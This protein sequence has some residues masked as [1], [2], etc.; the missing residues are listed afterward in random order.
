MTEHEYHPTSI[1]I[2]TY[3]DMG[4]IYNYQHFACL[5]LSAV[6]RTRGRQAKTDFSIGRR[7]SVLCLPGEARGTQTGE[8]N[9][10]RDRQ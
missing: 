2:V 4:C 7:L 8:R 3:V 9:F 10:L 6:L 5:H 1:N